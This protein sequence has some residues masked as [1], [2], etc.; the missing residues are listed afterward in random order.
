MSIKTLRKRIALVAVSALGVGLLSVAPASATDNTA[1]DRETYAYTASGST[2]VCNAP[3]NTTE[4]NEATYGNTQQVGEVLS[5][6]K[7]YFSGGGDAAEDTGDIFTATITGP[8][9][10]S[11]FTDDAG[12]SN[13][14]A[15][16]TT[17]GGG[18]V[19][20]SVITTTSGVNLPDDMTMSFTGTGTVQVTFAF[21]D[22]VSA[23]STTSETL[24]VYTF[25]VS[26]SCNYGTLSVDNSFVRVVYSASASSSAPSSNNT[27]VTA[28]TSTA[29]AESAAYIKNG[30]TGFVTARAMDKSST[31][32]LVTSSAT[33]GA[34]ATN[35]AIVSF[36]GTFS[37]EASSVFTT[38]ANGYVSVHV[39]QGTANKDKPL[40]TDVTIT[41]NGVELGKRTLKFTGAPT[42]IEIDPA[43]L[44]VGKSETQNV[45]TGFYSIYDA[46]GNDLTASGQGHSG[47]AN[48]AP[49]LATSGVVV[50]A[51][52]SQVTAVGDINGEDGYQGGFGWTCGAGSGSA[53]IYLKY[54]NTTT[55]A[56]LV[57]NTVDA[58]CA[59]GVRKYEASLDK[60]TYAPGEIATLTITATDKNGKPVY[61]LDGSGNGVDLGTLAK[62]PEISLPQLTAVTAATWSDEFVSGKKTYKFTVGSTEGTYS[63]I[64]NLPEKNSATYGVAA[65]TVN[66]KVAAPSTGAVT[67]AEVLAAIVKLIASINKQIRALQKSLKR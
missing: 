61:D 22:Y 7:I 5:T 36:D 65:K 26:S 8:G 50:D 47:S 45:L 42:K 39:Q 63:G 41:Y 12:A 30:S 55:L 24:E 17:G 35:G 60:A 43:Y 37:P 15:T 52:Q 54:V 20:K 40:T 66:Y 6:G 28:A 51:T 18:K 64:V 21:T 57:S 10:W 1:I 23:S 33:W 53:K 34:S 49:L 3:T 59:Y 27:D 31:P 16:T 67:N 44:S 62:S 56:T 58:S 13:D 2:Q 48:N 32:A 14:A 38:T 46:A 19:L 29:L 11:A 25:I 4:A 9:Y